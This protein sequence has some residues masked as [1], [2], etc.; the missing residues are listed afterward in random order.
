MFSL[1]MFAFVYKYTKHRIHAKSFF[2]LSAFGEIME[3]RKG[4]RGNARARGGKNKTEILSIRLDPRMRYLAELASRRQRRSISS[5]VEASIQDSLLRVF[6]TQ[7]VDSRGNYK[8]KTITEVA[9]ILWDVIEADRF[10]R[11]AFRY[12]DLLTYSEQMCWKSIC[13]NESFWKDRPDEARDRIEANLILPRLREKWHLFDAVIRGERPH[14]Q[15]PKSTVPSIGSDGDE[16]E[17]VDDSSLPP[18]PPLDDD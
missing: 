4:R 3:S 6:V 8:G 13:E 18:A 2:E 5:F 16:A 10:A 14:D 17:N 7:E 12:P 1:I 9:A 11:L 15:L